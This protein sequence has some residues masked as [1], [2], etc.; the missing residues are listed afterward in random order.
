MIFFKNSFNYLCLLLLLTCSLGAKVTFNIE[1]QP[2]ALEKAISLPCSGVLKKNDK[3]LVYLDVSNEFISLADRIDLPGRLQL[4]PIK[5]KSIGAHIPVF[6]ASENVTPEELGIEIPFSVTEIR[7]SLVKSKEGIFKPWEIAVDSSALSDLRQKYGCSPDIKG[8]FCI[9]IGKQFPVAPEG[10][11]NIE[12]LSIYNFSEEPTLPMA[13][14]GDF[15]TVLNEE[16]LA[17]A[18][19][20]DAIGQ[21]RLKNNGFVYLDVE[22]DFIKSITPFL[23]IKGD[24]APLSI[25]GKAMGAH[26][27]VLHENETITNEIWTL[28][29]AGE[30]FHFKVKELRYVDR[31]TEK[32]LQRLW[33]L[34]VD[35]PAL[36]RLRSSYG[37]KPKLQGH[38]FHITIGTEKCAS[39]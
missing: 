13:S 28:Q 10:S 27:S 11:E 31:K 19:K 34:A 7:S 23:E 22:N 1:H 4:P 6:L 26:I 14:K 35:S 5:S 33:L 16:M 8:D 20:V 15:V 12:T 9:R 3:G 25:K 17:T 36:Q 21:L 39:F 30:W 37:L 2:A 18:I 32:G 29:N 38:D 24:F